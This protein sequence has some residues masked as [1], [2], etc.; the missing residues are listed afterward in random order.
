MVRVL[1]RAR[2]RVVGRFETKDGRKVVLPYDPKIDAVIR[3]EDGETLGAREGEIVEARLT[4]FPDG[5]RVAHGVVEEKLGFLGEPGVD[6]EIV[7]RSHN[8]PTAVP[9]A[10]RGRGRARFR[11]KSARRT[12]S[13][14]ATSATTGSSRSTARPP[15]TSTTPSRSTKNGSG[16]RLGVHIADVSH[17]VRRGLGARRRGALARDVRLLSRAACC[18]CS[19]SA[20]PTGSAR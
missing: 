3:I 19:R 2:E 4:D 13:A 20:S 15:R 7:L 17:Y 5:R 10:G 9:G 16:Y 18:R 6:I 12:C 1:D 11:K 14:G 8:L